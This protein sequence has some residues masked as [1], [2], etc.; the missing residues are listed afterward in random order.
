ML[1]DK[2]KKGFTLN[3]KGISASVES[4]GMF[5]VIT[6]MMG[7]VLQVSIW[8]LAQITVKSAAYEAARGG[9]KIGLIQSE[10]R[11]KTIAKEYGNGVIGFW[12]PS[13]SASANSKSGEITVIITQKIPII[14]KIFPQATVKGIS[15]EIIEEIA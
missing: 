14:S 9:A 13:I 7:L 15:K 5:L 1:K 2:F 6:L 4:A 3:K 8:S 10:T 11:A 12:N